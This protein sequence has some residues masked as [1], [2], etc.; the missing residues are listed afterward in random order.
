MKR[1]II[2]LGII[3]LLLL[4]FP[5]SE[6]TDA[7]ETIMISTPEELDAVRNDLDGNYMLANDIDMSGF[8][9]FEPIGN[10]TDGA[11]TGTF[12]G[13]GYAII[14]LDLNYD[15]YKYV[16]LF[17]YLD[18]DVS[19]ITLENVDIIGGRYVGGIA[20]Y[21]D[22]NANVS[23]CNVSGKIVIEDSYF[24]CYLGGIVG[25][26]NCDISNCINEA[27]LN[28][29][30]NSIYATNYIAGI[31]G[32]STRNISGC[33]NK[34]SQ[35]LELYSGDYIAGIAAYAHEIQM[36]KNLG[37]IGKEIQ[38]NSNHGAEEAYGIGCAKKSIGDCSNY[39]NVK[40]ADKIYGIGK[41][42]EKDI[43][44][45]A[46]YGDL[47]TRW[48]GYL[49]S[50]DVYGIGTAN[51]IRDSYNTGK[52]EGDII[53]GVGDAISG[54]YRC[55]DTGSSGRGGIY[56]ITRSTDSSLVQEC[57]SN[58]MA[59][60]SDDI[61][62]YQDSNMRFSLNAME[63]QFNIGKY[64]INPLNNTSKTLKEIVSSEE[65]NLL[66][67]EN[68]WYRNEAYNDGIP[69]P[70][71]IPE[72]LDLN[73]VLLVLNPGETTQL[74]GYFN[75]ERVDNIEWNSSNDSVIVEQ[76]G[77]IKA[78]NSIS[79]PVC[80]TAKTKD[81][82]K[83]NCA[84]YV[85]DNA[86]A[87]SR[88]S[89]IELR[90]GMQEQ[91]IA[92]NYYTSEEE[93]NATVTWSSSNDNVANVNED[94][95]VTT[96]GCGS[97]T[98]TAITSTGKKDSIYINVY[99]SELSLDNS[100][101]TVGNGKTGKITPV[102]SPANAKDTFTYTSSNTSVATVDSSGTVTGKSG[103]T[104]VITVKSTGGLT[105]ECTV[106]VTD[107]S[108]PSTATV[109]IN[110]TAKISLT[111]KPTDMAQKITWSS[112]DDSIVTVDDSG[113][114]TGVSPGTAKIQAVNEQ[115]VT[116]VCT[117]T[118]TGY[119]TD[120]QLD[121]TSIYMELGTTDKILTTLTPEDATDTVKYTSSNSSIVSVDAEGVLT[122]KAIG[123]AQITV[124][125][126]G[127][128]TRYCSVV[129]SEKRI[130]AG[131][132]QLSDSEVSLY[133]DETKFL[134]AEV[135]PSNAT[136]SNVTWSSENEEIA[137]VNQVGL[138]T[139]KA[140]GQT[141]ITASLSNGLSRKCTVKVK[142][143][144]AAE[145]F[146]ENVNAQPGETIEVPVCIENNTGIASARIKLTYD[147]DTLTPTG[148]EAGSLLDR[149]QVAGNAGQTGEYYILWSNAEDVAGDGSLVNV[150]FTVSEGISVGESSEISLSY[151]EGDIC[152][153]AHDDLSVKV[154]PGNV[155]IKDIL[156]GDVYE[157][158]KLNS[159]DILLL[160]QYMTELTEFSR[161][162]MELGDMDEDGDVTMKDVVALAKALVSPSAA[163]SLS[164]NQRAQL[165]AM[166]KDEGAF[167]IKIGSEELSQDGMVSVPVTFENC[168]GISAFKFKV[169]YNT[170]AFT[171]TEIT[172]LTEEIKQSLM[173]NLTDGNAVFT[174][175]SDSD[176]KLDGEVLL[177]KFRAKEENITENS[178][179]SL[180]Y[181]SKNICN[182][183]MQNFAPSVEQGYIYPYAESFVQNGL[184]YTI[185]HT[186]DDSRQV[187][188]SAENVSEALNTKGE[189]MIPSV[190]DY[191]GVSYVVTEIEDN[192]FANSVEIKAVI[193]PESITAIG[194]NVFDGC[195][196]LD[197]I[198]FLNQ[199]APSMDKDSFQNVPS[200]VV[201][202]VPENASGYSDNDALSDFNVTS[203]H[204]HTIVVD[205]AVAATCTHTGLTEG[206][207]CSVCGEV[208]V[209]QEVIAATGHRWDGGTVTK[210]ATVSSTGI[211][212]YTCNICGA[213]KNEEIPKLA[214]VTPDPVK[215]SAIRI[216]G[217]SKKI[218]AGKRVKL[219][220]EVS[221]ANAASKAVI[222]RSSN[223]KIATVS[224]D[225]V[226][227]VKKRTG[228]QKVI[229]TATAADG[230][231]VQESY[232]IKSMKGVVKKVAVSG[233]KTVKAGKKLK[234]KARVTATKKAN[235]KILWISAN[236]KLAKVSSSGVVKTTKAAKG[237]KV[238]ITAMATDGSNK[239]KTVTI[240]VC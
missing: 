188:V 70:K 240:R 177:L 211:R 152:N 35:T 113:T 22:E 30:G 205:K 190:V 92:R 89:S 86:F 11:F 158:E 72:H 68:L 128:L 150:I 58:G 191:E 186:E 225:G 28:K 162:Q 49:V 61:N 200:D 55:Y 222:W 146:V 189:L 141:V 80:V 206:K 160:Q 78:K 75:G 235:K 71:N 230:S 183:A 115:G 137:A 83:M 210:P 69:I 24:T 97:T 157:D 66:D 184:K 215:V 168:P 93:Q 114:I 173:C 26:S 33:E 143:V 187:S 181:D 172:G 76:T 110:K 179:V 217:I 85:V 232:Q 167:A 221:P 174:W 36:C 218:A 65:L 109:N 46:N 38:N 44:N 226:V 185:I 2:L 43:V 104:A 3:R 13:N 195:E 209:K 73:H 197:Q 41:T 50:D 132:L 193:I 8:Y 111:T 239:K 213:R 40:G 95:M 204:T 99:G 138:I 236:P 220:A 175:Y 90:V 59:Y 163:Q 118:V 88:N 12:D 16:G 94:G 21:A 15:S 117:V 131:D 5:M 223:S 203:D 156:L 126:T 166:T 219:T 81:G 228:G 23:D 25:K 121:R 17:G 238:K 196:N 224:A 151:E 19:N 125:T 182:A 233:A 120:M 34:G 234:L 10:E 77:K 148:V 27:A 176:K 140:P 107:I 147:P 39:G 87:I 47:G 135:V 165:F 116:A 63:N 159:H 201:I 130:P 101:I 124:T 133:P 20:G 98:I 42:D 18:G 108:L 180:T 139:A 100:E 136:N 237:K 82:F 170:D 155:F 123:S 231:G 67:Y 122:A 145:I 64:L 9:T 7:A 129:V 208:L 102:I 207:H 216:N 14:D 134:T 112:L 164:V 171:L 37:K 53:R 169:A 161:H 229:I 29:N 127:G 198:I 154:K 52:I 45:C 103:G 91:L 60:S 62:F 214:P 106:T 178:A 54:I 84:V 74:Y 199:K 192:A 4:W 149:A 6:Q 32:Y 31:V 142:A 56:G 212:T 194:K 51:E 57:F 96:V 227:S 153:E 119:A 79:E 48:T 202:K 144:S 1:R 105:A